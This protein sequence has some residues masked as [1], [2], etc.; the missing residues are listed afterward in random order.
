MK[1]LVVCQ[2]YWPDNFLITEIAE[3][4][5]K[6]GHKVTV[7]TGL[8]DY[9]TTKIKTNPH[10]WAERS[11]GLTSLKTLETETCLSGVSRKKISIQILL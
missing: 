4:L 2:Y 8:P 11:I 1:I 10:M 9:S 7:L 6:R 3:D 5:V